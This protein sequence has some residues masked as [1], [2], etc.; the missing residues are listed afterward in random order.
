MMI[1]LIEKMIPGCT[2]RKVILHC[3]AFICTFASASFAQEAQTTGLPTTGTVRTAEE[4]AVP[5]ATVRLTNTETNKSWISWTDESGKF[6]FPS[7]PPGHYRAEASQLGFVRSSIEIQ[8]PTAANAPI[9]LVLRVATLAELSTEAEKAASKAAAAGAE[10][11]AAPGGGQN[12]APNASNTPGATGAG[13]RGRNG[14]RGGQLP[15]GVTNAIRQGMATGG[16]QQTELTGEAGAQGEEN[17]STANAGSQQAPSLSGGLGGGSAASS[18]SFLLQGTVGQSFS[19]NG[20]GGFGGFGGPGGPGGL[21]PGAP[22]VP[23]GPGGQGGPGGFGG[24]GRGGPG[25]G[26][27]FG[28]PGGPGGGGRMIRQQVNRI[29][30]G[31]YDQFQNS[32]W[33]A[34]PFSITGNEFPKVSHYDERAGFNIGGPMKIPHVYN[35]SDKTYFFINYQHEKRTNPVN[36]FSVVPTMDERGGN[37]G[38]LTTPIYNPLS[39][40]GDPTGPRTQ[41]MNNAIPTGMI[42][43]AANKLLAFI[44]LPN[45]AINLPGEPFNFL[46]QAATPQNSNNLNVH[47]LHTINAKFNVSVGYNY[48]GSLQNTLGNFADIAGTQATR[49]QNVDLGLTQNWTPRL[50]NDTHLN[51]SRSRIRVLSD[52]AFVNDIAGNVGITGISNDPINDGF[53]AVRLTSFSGFNDPV[54]NLTRNETWRISDNLTYVH[55]KHTMKFG[56]EVRR[57]QLNTDSGPIPRGQFSFTG[58]MTSQ[59][60]ASGNPVAGTGS[61]FA[62]FLLGF[63]YQ[64]TAR[65]GNP[66]TYFRSWDFIGYAQDDFRVNTKFTLQFGLR[67]EAVTPPVEL[68]NNIANLDMNAAATAVAQVTAGE[69]GP[70]SG[71]FPRALVHGDYGNLA[72][73]I[74]FAWQPLGKP[75]TVLRAGYSIFYNESI[76]N[77]L[78]TNYLAYQPPCNQAQTNLT[79]GPNFLTLENGFPVAA[80]MTTNGVCVA[81]QPSGAGRILNTTAVNPFYRDGYAQIW[82]LSDETTL[83][84]NWT[85]TLT[86]TGT[87]GTDLDLLRAP[88]RAPTGTSQLDTQNNFTI[89]N[90]NS[91]LYD[92][93]GGNSIYNALQVRLIHRFTNGLFFMTIYTYA[94]S[95]DDA[96]SIGGTSPTVVQQDNNFTA[97]YGLSSFDVR[98]QLRI[99]SL[100]ELPFGERHRYATHGWAEHVLSN[101]RVSNIFTWQTGTPVTAL[102]GGSAANNSGTGSNFSERA[103]MIA[104][105]NV[106][107][108]GGASTAFFNVNAFAVPAAGAFGD[109][110]RGSIEGPC[111][112]NW[113]ISV[114]KAFRFGANRDR[115]HRL[116]ARWEVQN[117]LNAVNFNGLSTT[118]GSTTFGRVTGAG[119]MR[120]MDVMMR[121]NF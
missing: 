118:F 84:K 59:L 27:G 115:P 26:G 93:S 16:F 71:A 24:G 44:P 45:P 6:E 14:G 38:A 60:D 35:G 101:W 68:F 32:I 22:G 117:V 52:N 67:Y 88:N 95:L 7:L 82:M 72:P 100:Y 19:S 49:N 18:D 57:I 53:P 13:A 69:T 73:R 31:I 3:L 111:S 114:A 78:A 4:V 15:A 94:K 98:H 105:P 12:A 113:N 81:A 99:I 20:P 30:F 62:D 58:L 8:I 86:Y 76:Y 37:F 108:C 11:P 102:L 107:I 74:G 33:D 85:L 91:F 97:E 29:R 47:V 112:F 1:P 61:D 21:A 75:K 64:T 121:F 50:V 42:D 90:A 89:P 80:S 55:N 40:L 70:F 39:N 87:K 25:G 17:A 83:S 110:R 28:G 92:Q 54:P 63:P 43:S 36:T 56:G 116:E 79:T 65:F 120:T 109:E 2:T 41:F 104:N 5:G 9:A 103:D 34:R 51:F 46:L 48:S 66:N 119:S 10:K 106:G 23:G 96:S 77:T